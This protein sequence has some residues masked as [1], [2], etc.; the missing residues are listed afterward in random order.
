MTEGG[1]C[2]TSSILEVECKSLFSNHCGIYWCDKVLSGYK[3]CN[4]NWEYY[5]LC[6]DYEIMEYQNNGLRYPVQIHNITGKHFTN[7][8]WL[9]LYAPDFG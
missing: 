4:Y 3:L 6:Y 2:L 1:H 7:H 5:M 8:W 9:T